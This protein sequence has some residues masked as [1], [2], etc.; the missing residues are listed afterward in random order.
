MRFFCFLFLVIGFSVNAQPPCSSSGPGGT[1]QSSISVCTIGAPFGQTNL[2]ACTGPNLPAVPQCTGAI[3]SNNSL[4]YKIHCYTS[5]TLGFLIQPNFPGDD[6]D[7]VLMDITNRPVGDVYTTNLAVSLNQKST[8]GST[9]CVSPPLGPPLTPAVNFTCAGPAG[10]AYNNLV[11]VLSGNE[12]LLMIT[13]YSSAGTAGYSLS[14][15][16]GTAL[17]TN[18]APPSVTTVSQVG[19][20]PSQ[21]KVNF[22]EDIKCSSLTPSGSEFIISNGPH[23]ISSIAYSCNAGSNSFSTLT[24]TLQN[25]LPP[26]SYTLTVNNGTL[27]D[28][29]TLLDVCDDQMIAGV[30]VPFTI[31]PQT[32]PTI[33]QVTKANCAGSI[34]KV[35]LSQPVTCA[36]ISP[37][38]SEFNITP[39]SPG[40]S[41]VTTNCGGTNLSTD[42]IYINLQNPLADGN[43]TLTVG[44]N[45][46]VGNTFTDN[47]GIP[48]AVG[49]NR[50]FTIATTPAPGVTNPPPYCQGA[51]AAALLPTGSN[52]LWYTNATGGT[53]STI[54]PTVSTTTAG[55]FNFY[56]S[57]TIGGCEGPRATITVTVNAAPIPPT[58]TGAVINYCVGNTPAILT[59]GGT[60]LLW[61][62]NATGGM[63]TSTAPSISTAAAGTTVYF[64]SQNN[65]TCES[66]TRTSITVNVLATPAAPTVTSPIDICQGS[67]PA[68]L[69]ASGNNL[70]WYTS[71]TGGSGTSTAPAP[72]TTTLGTTNY[73]V[74]QTT[75]G[76]INCE[77][78]RAQIIVNI[79]TT[80][81]APTVTSPLNYC[82]NQ[83]VTALAPSGSN[84]MWY[85][86]ATSTNGS[87]TPPTPSTTTI[88][89][90]LYYVAQS[91]GSCQGPRAAVIVNVAA[92]PA[93]PAVTTPVNYCVGNTAVPLP[94]PTG[95]NIK[96]YSLPTGGAFSTTAP[97]PNTATA[98]TTNYY[99]TQSIGTCESPRAQIPVVVTAIPVAP[100]V[101]TVPGQT[102]LTINYCQG[103]TPNN[104][105]VSGTNLLWYS[106][107]AG[108]VG[109]PV[110]PSVSTASV[111]SN[112]YYVSQSSVGCEGPRSAITVN[113]NATL[114]APTV[115]APQTYC[116]NEPTNPIV[117]NG[118]GTLKWYTQA[119]GGSSTTTTPFVSSAVPGTTTY[120]VSQT[121]GNCESP[122][123]AV[124]INI[125]ATPAAPTVSS[126]INFCPNQTVGPLSDSVTGT[127]L[128]WYASATGGSGSTISP[129]I[130]TTVF[131]AT[132]TFYVSQ[133]SSAASGSCEGPRAQITVNVDNFL[134]VSIGNDTT[135]CEGISVKFFPTVT[136]AG[137][138]YQWR[139]LN[140]PNSTIDNTSLL[141]ATVRPLNNSEY[142]LR[143]TFGGCV[144]EDSVKISVITKPVI[145]ISA[146]PTAI[147]IKDSSMLTGIVTRVTTPGIISAYK[148]TPAIRIRYDTALQ[149]YAYP[150]TSTLYTLT[151]TTTV[152]DYGCDFVS[153]GTVNV[154]VQPLVFANAGR[155][156]IAVK[157][158]PHQLQGSGATFY[159][160]SSPTATI[161]NPFAKNPFT[162]LN[163]DAV[164]Y[165]KATD[166]IGCFGTDTVFVKVLNGPAYY[167]PNAFTPNGDGQND[168]FRAIPAGLANTTYFRV[169][170][171]Y[172]VVMFET[173]QYLKGWDGTFNGKPQPAGVYVWMIAG[174][175][176]DFKKIELNGTVN[177]IR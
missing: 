167:V 123:A 107:P 39:G 2:P 138:V 141:N 136:P 60:N 143:A 34:L 86:T 150:V 20:N 130:N 55:T 149:T 98:G 73:Y 169:F 50:T 80:P 83:T 96:W 171:R 84:F 118:S 87:T 85:S 57:Q 5:G 100:Q 28:N 134:N 67:T 4:W 152:A 32:P 54:T 164:F 52:L 19:C 29:N 105:P 89:S 119:T 27:P 33:T 14:F 102:S 94:T 18:P 120:Y 157:G 46:P 97:T 110:A 163:D 162:V 108:G 122:R 170:N 90:T 165:L 142:V 36:S 81:A 161:S 146:S 113:V 127:N 172:G 121:T 99:V 104:F 24:L 117:V 26:G 62:T 126:I 92:T 176:K 13:R 155:D 174:T 160:W 74:S 156:T 9:G 42:T 37:N 145:N 10:T 3:T 106:N 41:S 58:V 45:P 70:L 61:Y 101:G 109:N 114:P 153:T 17:L 103:E 69:T 77:S 7:W 124:T 154:I 72:L 147:C 91:A 43:Y 6:Y 51:T 93:A 129:I 151:A 49:T 30:P 48:M 173:N 159:E 144:R 12:Y 11:P 132:Y 148:W 140:E 35:A 68:Q 47:C 82:Q 63:G 31:P 88:G 56:V 1:A 116:Q 21:I 22:S 139:S 71:A 53:G 23:T 125:T 25:P 175:D 168:I 38:G 76:T 65:G 166:A 111:S 64:V 44:T 112:T 8:G 75:N 158:A 59:A 78:P 79:V 95:T 16:G 128:L 177:L 133:S 66:L 131:P 115:P 40:I 15:T 135:I 137:A